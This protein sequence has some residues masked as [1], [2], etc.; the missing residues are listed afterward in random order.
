M[1]LSD[2]QKPDN[3]MVSG[4]DKWHLSRVIRTEGMAFYRMAIDIS[5]QMTRGIIM[6]TLWNRRVIDVLSQRATAHPNDL[7]PVTVSSLQERKE[8][9]QNAYH[10]TEKGQCVY[11]TESIGV[12]IREMVWLTLNSLISKLSKRFIRKDLW[13]VFLAFVFKNE[14]PQ[15]LNEQ[16]C[17]QFWQIWEWLSCRHKEQ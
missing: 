2:T 12:Q 8:H 14:S 7:S 11:R 10:L 6:G 15:K 5:W 1:K 13:K 3:K 9:F 16:Y 17:L 4:Q